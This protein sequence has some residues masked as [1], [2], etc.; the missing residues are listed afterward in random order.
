MADKVEVMA[1]AYGYDR[2]ETPMVED[3]SLFVRGVGK[4]TDIVEKELYSWETAGGEHVALRPEGTASVVR[5]YVHHGMLNLAQPV[6]L[7]Y[8]GAMFRHDRP[9]A[10][11]FRQ[12]YQAGFECI[13]EADAVVDAQMVVMAWNILNE[14][15]I[16]ATVRINSID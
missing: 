12:F 7:W 6:K 14:L 8:L 9:Q 2:I 16:H 5:A 10:G 13:G 4:A 1:R 15:G 11:R 3:A